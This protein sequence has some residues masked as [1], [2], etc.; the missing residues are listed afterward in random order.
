MLLCCDLS[1]FQGSALLCLSKHRLSL[2]S[3][4]YSR[5]GPS[6][7][8]T[9]CPTSLHFKPK[10]LKSLLQDSGSGVSSVAVVKHSQTCVQVN[11]LHFCPSEQDFNAVS[12][13]VVTPEGELSAETQHH[14][15][16]L[17]RVETRKFHAFLF[18]GLSNLQMHLAYSCSLSSLPFP[19]LGSSVEVC[20]EPSCS[21]LSPDVRIHI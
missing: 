7:P 18:E 20:S 10:R 14:T 3:K 8:S 11:I 17:A 12:C 15:E 9:I 6:L 4:L 13:R 19:A 16:I 1:S 2:P 5:I 21:L